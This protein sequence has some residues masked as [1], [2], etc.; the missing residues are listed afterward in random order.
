MSLPPISVRALANAFIAIHVAEGTWDPHPL[1]HMRVQKLCFIADGYHLARRETALTHERPEL[2][3]QGPVF[4]DLYHALQHRGHRPLVHPVPL[5]PGDREL[6]RHG[7][8]FEGVRT[9]NRMFL[10]VSTFGLSDLAHRP[11]S[12]WKRAAEAHGFRCPK[13][14][15][16]PDA[17]IQAQFTAFSADEAVALAA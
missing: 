1:T 14:T 3:P 13:G 9:V 7:D 10:T 4:S 17:L 11:G 8:L 2:W 12:A 16:I 15:T 5:I 6:D